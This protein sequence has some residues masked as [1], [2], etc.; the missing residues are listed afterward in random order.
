[1]RLWSRAGS[2]LADT[3][4]L[5]S[6][7]VSGEIHTFFPAYHA[8]VFGIYRRRAAESPSYIVRMVGGRRGIH[9]NPPRYFVCSIR[10][11][12]RIH[13]SIR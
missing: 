10:V 2:R 4:V 13:P 7:H 6:L 12:L 9:V 8:L 3:L 1:M 5:T 11:A